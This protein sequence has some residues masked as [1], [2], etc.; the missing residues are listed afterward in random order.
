LVVIVSSPGK[1]VLS[2]K[3]V[4]RTVKRAE[5]AEKV[6]LPIAATGK[7]VKR[8]KAKGKAKIRLRIAFTPDGGSA[9]AKHRTVALIKKP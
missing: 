6:K 1:L 4:K 3:G 9:G 5:G 7:S 8:L 2:G